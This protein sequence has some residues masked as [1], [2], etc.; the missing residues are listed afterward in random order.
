MIYVLVIIQS[1]YHGV[2]RAGKKPF[3]SGGK[4]TYNPVELP[5]KTVQIYWKT[6]HQSL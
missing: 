1:W 2:R 5:K 4:I 3:E 6:V